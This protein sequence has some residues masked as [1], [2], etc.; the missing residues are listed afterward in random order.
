MPLMLSDSH[1]LNTQNYKYNLAKEVELILKPAA[2]KTPKDVLGAL[3]KRL[4]TGENTVTLSMDPQ[5]C[6][7]T[8]KYRYGAVP[9]KLQGRYTSYYKILELVTNYFKKRNVEIVE[10]KDAATA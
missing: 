4:Y 1:E 6:L 10:I 9:E 5:Y 3:D 8:V 7:W 2:G